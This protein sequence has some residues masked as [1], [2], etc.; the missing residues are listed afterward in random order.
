MLNTLASSIV[1]ATPLPSSF[2][3]GADES[4]SAKVIGCVL[5]GIARVLSAGDRNGVVVAAD[6]D[7]P[8]AA[9]RQD[10]HDVT[11]LDVA[12]DPALFRDSVGVE[13]DLQPRAV[14][15]HLVEDPLT[16]GADASR[17]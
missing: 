5:A 4:G 6:V 15:F 10:G 7:S 11:S 12:R 14:A 2:T 1:S 17:R 16:C 3:P 13:A 8:R 9:S